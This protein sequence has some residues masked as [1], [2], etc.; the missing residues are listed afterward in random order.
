MGSSMS[1]TF[2][3]SI[4]FQLGY[5]VRALVIARST[6]L[7]FTST[8]YPVCPLHL[9]CIR[10]EIVVLILEIGQKQ[11]K[12]GSQSQSLLY[13][14]GIGFEEVYKMLVETFCGLPVLQGQAWTVFAD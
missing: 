1:C 9:P 2:D 14:R 13:L 6:E 7:S 12:S 3:I 11:Q 5:R 4:S 10:Y 8:A